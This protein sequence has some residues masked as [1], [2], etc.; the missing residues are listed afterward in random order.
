MLFV[1]FLALCFSTGC[2]STGVGTEKYDW[3][4]LKRDLPAGYCAGLADKQCEI[5]HARKYLADVGANL[6]EKGVEWMKTCRPYQGHPQRAELCRCAYETYFKK[7]SDR[8]VMGELEA[9]AFMQNFTIALKD[10]KRFE[11]LQE[12]SKALC[13]ENLKI[14]RAGE[15]A[16]MQQW[17]SAT[18]L[19][20]QCCPGACKD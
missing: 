3:E 8:Q 19:K 14:F 11:K 10:P 1:G 16:C 17:G 2:V 13:K 18:P 20:E 6:C 9:L 7:A 12:E 4:M 15:A 5:K